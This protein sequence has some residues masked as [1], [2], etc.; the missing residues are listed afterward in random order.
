MSLASFLNILLLTSYKIM[1]ICIY[2]VSGA[3]VTT[4][5]VCFVVHNIDMSAEKMFYIIII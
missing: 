4:Q 3:C 5:E 2:N 1:L